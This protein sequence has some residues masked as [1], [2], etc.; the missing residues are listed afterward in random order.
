MREFGR[1]S[2]SSEKSKSNIETSLIEEADRINQ[3]L[4]SFEL[5]EID[6]NKIYGIDQ[7]YIRKTE[8]QE[9]KYDDLKDRYLKEVKRFDNTF[10]SN[11]AV[12]CV[13]YMASYSIA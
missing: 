8:K 11:D 13:G 9:I 7:E 3:L 1:I 6:R 5:D 2:E 12:I 4:D 10:V